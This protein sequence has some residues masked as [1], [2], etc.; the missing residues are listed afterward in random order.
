M[1]EEQENQ[2]ENTE[3]PRESSSNFLGELP[4]SWKRRARAAF[5]YAFCATMLIV[6]PSEIASGIFPEVKWVASVAAVARNI[7]IQM[8]HYGVGLGMG[9]VAPCLVWEHIMYLREKRAREREQRAREHEQRAREQAEAVAAAVNAQLQ[10]RVRALEQEQHAREREQRAREQ[11]EAVTAELQGRV[12]ALE[13]EKHAREQAEVVITRLQEEIALLRGEL[14][15]MK[16][17]PQPPRE[18]DEN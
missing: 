15:A 11:A 18:G 2:Q 12:R 10:E 3:Q 8:Y 14:D 16:T 17:R 13:A 7:G 9:I 4:E 6:V 1:K 5:G